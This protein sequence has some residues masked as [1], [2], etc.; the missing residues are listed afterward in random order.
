MFIRNGWGYE[1]VDKRCNKIQIMLENQDTILSLAVCRLYCGDDIGTVWPIPRG[2]VQ[3]IKHVEKIDIHRILITTENFKNDHEL[4]DMARERFLEMQMKKIPQKYPL[5]P[6]GKAV[7]IEVIVENDDMKLD[8]DTIE[9]YKLTVENLSP[10]EI[11][12][13]IAA[14]TFYGARHAFETLSQMIIHDELNHEIKILS[15][16]EIEDSPMFRHRGISLD[17]AR[18]YYPVSFLKKTINGLAMDKLNS[19]HWHITDS[20]SWPM[21][22]K[23]HPDFTLYGAYSAKKIYTAEDIKEIVKYGRARGIRIIPE[24]DAPAHIGAGFVI[25]F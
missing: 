5:V 12:I 1:C 16:V 4:W 24:L 7:E 3:F 13:K 19:L 11:T 15:S 9:S 10:T 8:Y 14:K 23:S 2:S 17:T 18:N 22:V 25:F 6:G 21:S 20:Q